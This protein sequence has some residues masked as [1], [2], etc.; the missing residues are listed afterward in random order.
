MSAHSPNQ[1]YADMF[2]ICHRAQNLMTDEHE[3]ADPRRS[4]SIWYI[5]FFLQECVDAQ[6][7]SNAFRNSRQQFHNGE[8]LRRRIAYCQNAKAACRML[9][10]RAWADGE[11]ATFDCH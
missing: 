2:D 11:L 5:G 7:V 1:L 10:K 3:D 4:S 8:D 9:G 6:Q